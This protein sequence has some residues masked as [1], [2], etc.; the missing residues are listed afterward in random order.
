MFDSAGQ[1][2]THYGRAEAF[3]EFYAM[4]QWPQATQEEQDLNATTRERPLHT[5]PMHTNVADPTMDELNEFLCRLERNKMH[6]P[7]TLPN[8]IWQYLDDQSRRIILDLISTLLHG[9]PLPSGFDHADLASLQKRA[10]A[11]MP[12]NYRPIS[13]LN[14]LYK[15]YAAFLKGRLQQALEGDIRNT[16]YAY[17]TSK[18]SVQPIQILRKFIGIYA[19]GSMPVTFAFLDWERA[20][21]SQVLLNPKGARSTRDTPRLD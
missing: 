12:K 21:N 13:R 15:I 18:S 1:V 8:E 7:D 19:C 11:S 4:H 17:Q 20:F 10:D 5:R 16:R 14:T 9:S 6:G 3:A 2:A